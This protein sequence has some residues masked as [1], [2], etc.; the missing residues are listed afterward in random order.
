MLLYA[1]GSR[2]DPDQAGKKLVS[3]QIK[4]EFAVGDMDLICNLRCNNSEPQ[5]AALDRCC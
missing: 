3:D 2:F 4:T 5:I 1:T